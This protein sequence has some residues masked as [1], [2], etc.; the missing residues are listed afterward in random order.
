MQFSTCNSLNNFNSPENKIEMVGLPG[1]EPGSIEPKSTSQ[2][3]GLCCLGEDKKF[4]RGKTTQTYMNLRSNNW[5]SILPSPLGLSSIPRYLF[6]AGFYSS[7]GKIG[8][9]DEIFSSLQVVI[10]A[11]RSQQACRWIGRQVPPSMFHYFLFSSCFDSP[12]LASELF[13][14]ISLLS[15]FS[16]STTSIAW[17][18]L[19]T[20]L[21][22][23][24]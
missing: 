18:L 19:S 7:V 16:N 5:T 12:A 15:M 21:A 4:F 20:V 14:S 10:I 11:K 2:D 3:H 8:A 22:N 24:F 9:L 17:R 13:S 1:F 6:T 23:V